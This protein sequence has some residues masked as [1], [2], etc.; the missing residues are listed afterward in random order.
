MKTMVVPLFSVMLIVTSTIAQ[1]DSN[2]HCYLL[3]GQS[4]MAG[5]G[6]G[7]PLGGSGSGTLITEDCDTSTR[8]KVLAFCNCNA[9]SIVACPNKA[10]QGRTAD[11]WYTASP[12]LHICGEG[13]SPGDWFAKTLLDSIRD[14][15][16]IGLIP[17][18]LSGQG[19]QVFVK[20]GSN[21]NIPNWAHPTLGNSSPYTWMLNR[22]KKAQETGVIKGILLHQG[23]SGSGSRPW[24][25]VAKQIMDDLKKDLNLP[26]TL[27][28]V[29][30]ELRQDAKACCSGANTAI[31][32]FSK[33]YPKCGLASSLNLGVQTND[34][35]YVNGQMKIENDPFHFNPEGM[36][37]FGK[38]YARAFLSIADNKFIPRKVE[39][40][41]NTPKIQRAVS[42][43]S[44]KSWNEN[45]RIFSLNGKMV[46]QSANNDKNDYLK[47]LQPGSIYVVRRNNGA[48][49][50]L[51]LVVP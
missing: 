19:L 23:E 48:S 45:V 1:V 24:G 32:N 50:Q 27:P 7:V 40:A 42:S 31:N 36:R 14:D 29:V 11:N 37:E 34:T 12:A 9:G 26:S 17:C 6:A 16:K 25:D 46:S 28:V 8:V 5:G 20:D 22:C 39:V 41:V 35:T 4:N 21:F 3:F 44:L 13:V 33:S 2:F 10:P 43:Q 18:A 30:G 15:I 51:M 49:T 38:R 47:G